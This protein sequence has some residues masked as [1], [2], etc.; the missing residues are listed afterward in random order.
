MVL[1]R[2][3]ALCLVVAC[4]TQATTPVEAPKREAAVAPRPA[5]PKP[6]AI[7]FVVEGHE[8]WVGNDRREDV[9]GHERVAGALDPLKEA[10]AKVPL[11]GL[12]AG[13]MAT[14]VTYGEQAAVRFP[15]APIAKLTPDAFGEQKDYAGIIDRDLVAGVTLG[16]DELAKVKEARR[17]LVV[18]GDGTDTNPEVAERELPA[19]AK[20]AA[21]EHVQIA[22]FVYKGRFSAPVDPIRAFDS[23]MQPVT[24]TATIGRELEA[25]FE[26]LAPPPVVG[27]GKG[28]ALVL[29]VSGAE[30]WMGND[31]IV[32]PRIR[33]TTGAP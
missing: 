19:L 15:M 8:M 11:A 14:V 31:D 12:P 26:E 32:P 9:P 22:T 23:N 1:W 27:D 7:A 5:P 25:L 29:L 10:L 20:R 2:C 4:S 6:V 18:I 28:T 24:T 17:V 16:L 30:V 3:V 33:R 21:A 13:S